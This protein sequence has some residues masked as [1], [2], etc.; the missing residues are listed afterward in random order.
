MK[1]TVTTLKPETN[2]RVL[3][4]PMLPC[5]QNNIALFEGSHASPTCPSD[6]SSVVPVGLINQLQR[7]GDNLWQEQSDGCP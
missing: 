4:C 1:I 3:F 6:K 7:P 5:I 2:L